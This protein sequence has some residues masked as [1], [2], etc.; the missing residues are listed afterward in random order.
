MMLRFV[1]FKTSK[2]QNFE[3]WYCCA[4]SFESIKFDRILLLGF[5][6]LPNLLASHFCSISE[7]QQN[8]LF[9]LFRPAAGLTTVYRSLLAD[10]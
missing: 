1:G 3:G 7:T 5:V 8:G 4:L 2:P 6:P 9:P 10:Q